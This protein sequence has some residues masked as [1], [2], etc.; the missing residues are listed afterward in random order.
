MA[1]P[2]FLQVT[3]QADRDPTGG[4]RWRSLART[5][6][7]YLRREMR[8]AREHHAELYPLS[9]SQHVLRPVPFIWRVARELAT[10]YLR[11]PE[12]TYELVG[13][14][15]VDPRTV[16]RIRSVMRGAKVT[17]R[18]R[19]AHE[20]LVAMGNAT[21]WV[22]PRFDGGGGV[23]VLTPACYDQEVELK[24]GLLYSPEVSDVKTWWLR[25][26]VRRDVM[27]GMVEYGVAEISADKAFWVEGPSDIRG[28]GI[29]GSTPEDTSNPL[30]R[31]P[32]VMMR[33]SD[34]GPGEWWAPLPEDLL[35]GQRAIDND[36]TDS[37]EVARR[38]GYGQAVLRRSGGND[39]DV[40]VGYE[41]A[42]VLRSETDTFTF[43]TPAADLAGMQ[44]QSDQYLRMLTGHSGLNPNLFNASSGIT[45]LAKQMEILD[46]DTERSR[47]TVDFEQAEQ[48]LYN[49][50]KD[51]INV[52]RGDGET[53]VW[54]TADV[55]VDFRIAEPPADPQIAAT[56]GETRYRT[57]QSSAARDRSKW[58]GISIEEAQQRV[59]EDRRM[60]AAAEAVTAET[61]MTQTPPVR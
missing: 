49:L 52:L 38:L 20:H 2:F 12:R 9:G 47:Y 48:D 39:D 24:P 35:Y 5:L 3:Q 58:E 27:T 22:W 10:L 55:R 14:L 7:E 34:P 40:R 46:R 37:G 56:A 53:E 25:M 4:T 30:G 29:F 33:A 60:T 8:D 57:G 13:G 43:E 28:M 41:S 11:D 51:W 19:T 54:P 6:H 32:V 42:V 26:P 44:G 59:L 50:A 36:L 23:R 18:F 17:R 45:A 15:P 31:V 21:L 16:E 61:T 1:T